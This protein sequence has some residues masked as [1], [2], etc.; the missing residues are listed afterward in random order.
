MNTGDGKPIANA[1]PIFNDLSGE[2]K[3]QTDR[4]EKVVT[5]DLPAFNAEAK[6]LGLELVLGR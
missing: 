6:R 1:E 2:L 5:S 4:L 3:V